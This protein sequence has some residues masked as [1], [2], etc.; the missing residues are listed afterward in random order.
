MSP[1]PRVSDALR[2]IAGDCGTDHKVARLKEIARAAVPHAIEM[3][4]D[5]ERLKL[6]VEHAHEANNRFIAKEH[7]HIAV[8]AE[9]DRLREAL[10]PVADYLIEVADSLPD[11]RIVS[12]CLT[13]G[14]IRAA[15]AALHPTPTGNIQPWLDC[16]AAEA[17]EGLYGRSAL[18]PTEPAGDSRKV[19]SICGGTAIFHADERVWRHKGHPA[20]EFTQSFCAKYGYPIE[21]VDGALHPMEPS[22]DAVGAA[23]PAGGA[24]E[25][26][27]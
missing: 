21:V 24:A 11:S 12:P 17:E 19:C 7:E 4:A 2:S 23:P 10:K 25:E 1:K 27:E 20:I 3:E 15:H 5:I 13:A 6:E 9:R 14:Q 8:K 26:R 18:H 16:A 22:I